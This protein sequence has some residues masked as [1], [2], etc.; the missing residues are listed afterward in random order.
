[1]KIA[2]IMPAYNAA[3]YIDE[4]I[5]S[6]I[7]QTYENWELLIVDDGSTDDT[8]KIVSKYLYDKRI[9]YIYQKNVGQASARNNG[10]NKTDADYI[11]FLDSDDTWE[12]EKLAKQLQYFEYNNIDLVYGASYIINSNGDRQISQMKPE[13]G[14]YSGQF[15]VNKLILGTF[16]IP[17]LTVMVKKNVL[18]NAGLF[19]ESKSIK[20]AEDFD[21]W[22]RIASKGYN[23][24]CISEILSNYRIHE[25][26][27]TSIDTA[28]TFQVIESLLLFK[29]INYNFKRNITIS[30]LNKLIVYFIKYGI[31]KKSKF[32]ITNILNRTNSYFYLFN[33][34]F[35]FRFNILF[36]IY[37]KLR[38]KLINIKTYFA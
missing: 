6:V 31:P 15:L 32:E 9:K 17:I 24:M 37:L 14:V 11:A 25:N 28:S 16:F 23:M 21:L 22:L 8:K 26:Q 5:I 7:N 34:I 38:I 2:V 27:S 30:I 18:L 12:R 33:Y 4:S 19:N 10:I 36:L 1:M 20:N 13:V 29:N 3:T 35:T